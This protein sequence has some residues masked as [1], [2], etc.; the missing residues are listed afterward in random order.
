MGL[1]SLRVDPVAG[2]ST[3]P[4]DRFSLQ[5]NENLAAG[6]IVGKL[7]AE[8]STAAINAWNADK[9]NPNL[10]FTAPVVNQDTGMTGSLFERF[11]IVRAPADTQVPPRWNA[12][13]WVVRVK[14]AVTPEGVSKFDFENAEDFGT[15]MTFNGTTST[16]TWAISFTTGLKD[17]NEAPKNVT[18]NGAPVQSGQLGS[19]VGTLAAFDEDDAFNTNDDAVISYAV[20]TGLDSNLFEIINNTTLKVKDNQ[21]LTYAGAPKTDQNGDKYYEVN[22]RVTDGGGYVGGVQDPSGSPALSRTETL[23]VYVAQSTDATPTVANLGTVNANAN[24]GTVAPFGS[25]T[26][27]NDAGQATTATI[28]FQANLGTLSGAGTGTTNGNLITYTVTGTDAADLQAKLRALTFNPRDLGAGQTEDIAI[29]VTVTDAAH[30]TGTPSTATVR[31]TAPNT[32]PTDPTAA[33]TVDERS[34]D[35]TV[36]L[37]MD[38]KDDDGQVITY[39]FASA[40]DAAKKISLDGKFRIE[41]NKIVA[42]GMISEVTQD[43]SLPFYRVVADDGA[44]GTVTGEVSITVKNVPLLSIGQLTTGPIVEGDTDFVDYVFKVDRDSTGITSRAVWTVTGNG[45]DAN[46]FEFTTGFVDFGTNDTSKNIILRVKADRVAEL[47]ETFTI[48]LTNPSAGSAIN[49]ASAT[50]TITDDDNAPTF[51]ILNGQGTH[52]GHVGTDIADVLKGVNIGDLDSDELTLTVEFVNAK[53]TLNGMAGA[54]VDVTDHGTANNL[55]KFTLKGSAAAIETLLAG[56]T[57]TPASAGQ[58]DFSFT[59]SD[60][61]NPLQTFNNA[62]SAVGTVPDNPPPPTPGG[63]VTTHEGRTDGFVVKTLQLKDGAVD[64]AYTFEN[65]LAGNDKV[66]ADGRYVIVGNEVRVRGAGWVSVTDDY[67]DTYRITATDNVTA[68]TGGVTLR[69]KNNLGPTI[70]SIAH[71]GSG[72]AGGGA[73]AGMIL[74]QETAGAVEIGSVTASDRDAA[75]DGRALSYSLENTYNDLFSIDAAGKIRIADASKLPVNGDTPYALKVRVSDG[76]DMTEQTVTVKVKE[77]SVTPNSAPTGLALS[78]N[79]PLLS[80]YAVPGKDVVG[81]L[82]A[83]DPN[84]DALTYRLIENAGNRFAIDGNKLVLAGPGVN[85]EDVA[86]HQVKVEVSDGRGGTAQQVFTIGIKDET[87]ETWRGTK[88]NDNKTGSLLDDILRG[89]VGTG[90]DT[91]KGGTGDDKLYGESGNDSVLGGDGIDSLFGGAGNDTLK[92]DAGKDLVKGDAGNDK[93]YGGLDNDML[94]GGNGND[95]LKGDA[96]DDLLYGE[97]G[98]DKLYG[99]LGKDTFVFNKK[100]SKSANL[101]KIMDFNVLDDTIWLENKVFKKLGTAGSE[102]LPAALN[103]VNFVIGSKAKDRNDH[104]VYN[105]KKGILYYDADGSGKGAAVEIATMKKNL[106]L[107]IDDFKII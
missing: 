47:A 36:V 24:V 6:T 16:N 3:Q 37:T 17:V 19:P 38:D 66:S 72:Q 53:G 54:G 62:V 55:R 95:I 1:Y 39:T 92:G 80:E 99:G 58:T 81:T 40:S 5:F 52:S 97:A 90:K 76:T 4:G 30:P 18:H 13:D 96:G 9:G 68:V 11:E 86:S 25:V 51:E 91:I 2:L 88:K 75:L 7:V 107:T 23:R 10:S 82:S 73:E 57:F 93:A 98:N 71:S 45:I 32:P 103:A 8:G 60:G 35:G 102:A 31:S 83:T 85:F 74:V 27:T 44:G 87:T 70:T 42:N 48:T 43:T 21:A 79:A 78:L 65:H 20:D 41:G 46:D 26:I 29:S 106:K 22:I 77:T 104:I 49:V 89:G 59:L 64:I 14:E 12:G 69:V 28:T 33:T 105:N 101:D 84:G 63:D 61:A 50:G 67:T 56:V 94:Y 100:P 15:R 34:G